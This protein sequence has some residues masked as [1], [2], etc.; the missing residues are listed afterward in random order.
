MSVLVPT[1]F[2][3]LAFAMQ[4]GVVTTRLEGVERGL[5]ELLSKADA[6]CSE[7]KEIGK[8]LAYLEGQISARSQEN[9]GEGSEQ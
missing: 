8:R 6:I 3:M 9:V 4:W 5:D 1:A 7:S 2:A